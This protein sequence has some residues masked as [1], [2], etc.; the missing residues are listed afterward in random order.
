MASLELLGYF[1]KIP[2]A[3]DFV[4]HG[5]PVRVT[6]AWAEIAAG[7]MASLRSEGE[8][9]FQRNV[10]SS[11]VWRFL[12]PAGFG[13]KAGVNGAAGLMAGSIDGAGRA[14][15]FA[16]LLVSREAAGI[17]RPD[18]RLDKALDRIEAAMLGFMEDQVAKEEFVETLKAVTTDLSLVVRETATGSPLLAEAEKAACFIGVDPAWSGERAAQASS[19]SSSPATSLSLNPASPPAGSSESYWWHD[20][21]APLR[22]SQFYVVR[23]LPAETTARPLFFADWPAGWQPRQPLG[24]GPV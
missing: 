21:H 9:V 6:E 11:P 14:F 8:E 16:V 3:R 5:L 15:P 23:G 7:W 2:A 4:F 20:G 1:G 24:A 10:L 12:M 17:Q 18:A 19:L 13:G 22:P